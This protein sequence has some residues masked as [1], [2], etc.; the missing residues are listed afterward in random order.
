MVGWW[1]GE[2]FVAGIQSIG[3]NP[4][5]DSTLFIVGTVVVIESSG[6]GSLTE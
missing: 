3:I 4:R 1:D 5:S 2:V 6:E